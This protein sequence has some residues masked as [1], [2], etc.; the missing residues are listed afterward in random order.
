MFLPRFIVLIFKFIFLGFMPHAPNLYIIFLG[1][2]FINSWREVLRVNWGKAQKWSSKKLTR[3]KIATPY[4][5]M[6]QSFTINGNLASNIATRPVPSDVPSVLPACCDSKLAR[7]QYVENQLNGIWKKL[8][9]QWLTCRIQSN[10]HCQASP[11]T[12]PLVQ[13]SW[14]LCV[15]FST[16]VG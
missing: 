3:W 16:V 7:C 9:M 15:T 13:L 8:E 12:S 6:K 14:F 2:K 1:F 4:Q 5:Y 10:K 11:D